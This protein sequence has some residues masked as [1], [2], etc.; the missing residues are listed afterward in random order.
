MRK[1]EKPPAISHNE[2]LNRGDLKTIRRPGKEDVREVS[3]SF[4][5]SENVQIIK[6]QCH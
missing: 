5:K 6:N 3:V 2:W 4:R 1:L